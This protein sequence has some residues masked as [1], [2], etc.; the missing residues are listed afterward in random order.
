MLKAAHERKEEIKRHVLY[1]KRPNLTFDTKDIDDI[2][3]KVTRNVTLSKPGDPVTNAHTFYGTFDR[4]V[5]H[6]NRE[7]SKYETEILLSTIIFQSSSWRI[8]N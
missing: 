2:V 8:Y 5:E 4:G 1:K 7:E 6:E 3:G